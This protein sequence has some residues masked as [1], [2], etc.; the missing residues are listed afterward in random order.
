[1]RRWNQYIEYNTQYARILALHV[2]WQTTRRS[3][4]RH[5]S[6][7]SFRI[8]I[9]SLFVGLSTITVKPSVAFWIARVSSAGLVADIVSR[10]LVKLTCYVEEQRSLGGSI[11]SRIDNGAFVGLIYKLLVF[12]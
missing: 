7:R 5:A 8:S 12:S 6:T 10:I 9:K 2:H 1:M 11:I 4:E 3:E